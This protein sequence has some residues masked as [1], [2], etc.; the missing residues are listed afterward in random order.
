MMAPGQEREPAPKEWCAGLAVGF[1]AQEVLVRV[2]QRSGVNV[3]A[4][5]PKWSISGNLC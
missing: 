4:L 5:G 1:S 3:A 2:S